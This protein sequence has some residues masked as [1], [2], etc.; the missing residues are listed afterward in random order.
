MMNVQRTF[1]A[2]NT[3]IIIGD[4]LVL[5][6]VLLCAIVSIFLSPFLCRHVPYRQGAKSNDSLD[7]KNHRLGSTS[8]RPLKRCGGVMLGKNPSSGDCCDTDRSI[9]YAFEPIDEEAC[10]TK[11]NRS[12]YYCQVHIEDEINLYKARPLPYQ[13]P[14]H[15]AIPVQVSGDDE[16][17]LDVTHPKSVTESSKHD[18]HVDNDT[19]PLT[20]FVADENI[21][22]LETNT[23]ER[24]EFLDAKTERLE[25]HTK[26]DSLEDKSVREIKFKEARRT[27]KKLKKYLKK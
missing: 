10:I 20:E 8:P 7:F 24:T 4:L 2:R 17:D 13:S 5:L 22:L 25:T 12:N 14:V 6:R 21:P 11:I 23:D 18:D 15:T 19:S 26:H 27:M 16:Q 9:N 1:C 3:T